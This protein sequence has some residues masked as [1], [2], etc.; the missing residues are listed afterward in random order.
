MKEGRTRSSTKGEVGRQFATNVW[1]DTFDILKK[2]APENE[3]Y[4]GLLQ[5]RNTE[6]TELTESQCPPFHWLLLPCC[7]PNKTQTK[8]QTKTQTK[9]KQQK[10]H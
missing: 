6:E 5:F 7:G 8:M 2:I 3:L 1:N 10:H 4:A 9:T